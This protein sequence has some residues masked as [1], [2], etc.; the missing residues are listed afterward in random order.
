MLV[1]HCL[2]CH[3]GKATKGGLDL[4]DRKP[5]V[6]SGVLEGGGKESRL[7]AL[8]P[9]RRRAAHAAQGPEARRRDDRRDRA[10]DRPGC[11]L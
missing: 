1:Q 4:S 2:N 3:G 7:D 6:E 8:D 9:A 10:L 5:L 11:A